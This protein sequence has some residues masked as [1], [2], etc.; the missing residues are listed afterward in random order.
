MSNFCSLPIILDA[1]QWTPGCDVPVKLKISEDK[2]CGVF[3][4]KYGH[5]VCVH[6]N[7]WIVTMSDNVFVLPDDVFT[8]MYVDLKNVS[9]DKLTNFRSMV[10][11]AISVILQ[12]TGR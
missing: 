11:G 10:S 12:P 7:D 4:D 8:S 6:N 9:N 3:V 1:V 2:N 5:E